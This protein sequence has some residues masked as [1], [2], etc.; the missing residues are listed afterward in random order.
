MALRN[1]LSI[2]RA[3]HTCT[4]VRTWYI[5][6]NLVVF[7]GFL[8]VDPKM[9]TYLP[10]VILGANAE[11]VGHSGDKIVHLHRNRSHI[12]VVHG[13]AFPRRWRRSHANRL[14]LSQHVSAGRP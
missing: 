12:R 1:S 6:T 7:Y 2:L 13:Y 14:P 4:Y 10:D 9:R 8:S 3:S 11:L 5:R